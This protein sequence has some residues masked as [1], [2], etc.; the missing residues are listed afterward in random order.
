MP[1]N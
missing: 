1:Y